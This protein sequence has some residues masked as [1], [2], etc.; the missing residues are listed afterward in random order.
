ML[1]HENNGSTSGKFHGFMNTVK[2]GYEEKLFI[3][4]GSCRVQKLIVDKPL[5]SLA[6]CNNVFIG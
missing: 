2:E 1:N 5:R 6:V 4:K 3:Q